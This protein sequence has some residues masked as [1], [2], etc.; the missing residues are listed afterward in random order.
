[1]HRGHSAQEPAA[2]RPRAR[3]PESRHRIL[4]NRKP[5]PSHSRLHRG[6]L[7]G[8]YA[9]AFAGRA[10]AELAK[11]DFDGS[12][13]DYSRAIADFGEAL[14]LKPGNVV[15]LNNRGLA[16]RQKANST[17]PLR[18]IRRR[19]GSIPSA[20]LPTTTAAMS[21]R[22]RAKNR[23]PLT[24]FARRFRLIPRLSVPG[25]GLKRLGADATLTARN[26]KPCPRGEG[27]CA[28]E[29][30]LVSRH[31]ST[32]RQPNKNA[33]AF[34]NLHRGY[35]ILALREPLSR[36]IARP[37]DVMPNFVLSDRDIDMIVA[38]V[39]SLSPVK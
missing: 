20:R 23:R 31:R 11:G 25:D 24:I 10:E 22:L 12:I 5:R 26:R 3:L 9:I 36:G 33:P 15:A 4:G 17:R 16:Y 8:D 14:R 30:C 6:P 34:R 13:A 18:I 2:G 1:V 32:R 7:K 37:H 27:P 39:N 35:P 38:Y 21:M 19:F 29:L 28:K